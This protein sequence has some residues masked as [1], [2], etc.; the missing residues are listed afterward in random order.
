MSLFE[1]EAKHVSH[2][3]I[4]VGG[5]KSIEERMK[6]LGEEFSQM[7]D[8]YKPNQAVIEKIFL[9][10]SPQS[11]FVLG[12]VRGVFIYEFARREIPIIELSPRSIKKGIAGNG[13]A[14][15]EELRLWTLASLEIE[16][17]EKLDATDA[18]AMALYGARAYN[19]EQRLSRNAEEG[20]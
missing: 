19:V 13:A 4:E 5:K 8:Q 11:A 10:K 20:L 15:K 3:T 7:L 12:Q 16:S 17:Q 2:G 18:L 1:G 14:S 9:G 6:Y